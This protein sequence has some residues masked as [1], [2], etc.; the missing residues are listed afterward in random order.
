M[1]SKP[2]VWLELLDEIGHPSH[3]AQGFVKALPALAALLGT[4]AFWQ[5]NAA[6]LLALT[7]GTG[8]SIALL[9]V[10]QQK[11]QPWPRV[12]QWLA[13]PQ[14][15]LAMSVST[16]LALLIATYGALSVWQDFHSPGLA[17]L[18]LTQAIG[19]F[20]VLGLAVWLLLSRQNRASAPIYSFDRCVAGLLHREELRR[21]V[22]VR[23]LATLATRKELTFGEQAIAAEYLSLLSRKEN[24]PII[25]RAIQESLAVLSPTRPQLSNR[26]S[27][28]D[29]VIQPSA[30]RT[31]KV[32][33]HSIS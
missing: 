12:Q 15:P 25:G 30:R 22:A 20:G 5:W 27:V 13:H 17:M 28:T 14:A 33:M 2:S 23:Q 3:L 21:L 16:G 26:S 24:D 4:I 29:R 11:R 8:G 19:I 18:L 10:L 32:A 1:L 31:E 6:L 9:Q 7:L